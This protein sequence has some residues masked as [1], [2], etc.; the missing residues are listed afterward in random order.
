MTNEARAQQPAIA[1]GLIFCPVN[2]FF[3]DFYRTD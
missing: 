1:P 2:E 3:L